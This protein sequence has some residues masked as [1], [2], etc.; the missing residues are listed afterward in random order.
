M[1][2]YQFITREQRGHVAIVRLNR[3]DACNA[4]NFEIMSEIEHVALAFRDDQQTRVVVFAGAGRHFSA[5]A[6]LKEFGKHTEESIAARRQRLRM[7]ER[8]MRAWLGVDQITVCAWNGGAI[9]GG[10]CLAL[11]TDFR[12]GAEDCYL[13][14]PEIDL[15]LNLMWQSLPRTVRM[16]GETRALRLVIGGERA[17]ADTLLGWDVLEKIVPVDR[18]IDSACEFAEIYA[19]KSPIAAQMI[20]RSV[21]AIGGSLDQAIMHM[22]ADQHIMVASTSDHST[23][24]DAYSNK[25]TGEFVGN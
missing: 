9:G 21:N 7:G 6:D 12:I 19:S 18:L 2:D 3:A 14:Y 1:T 10:G 8:V 15:G 11:A 23:A 20:K 13:Y 22:D 4:L 5:G 17:N 25:R 16:L 24:V